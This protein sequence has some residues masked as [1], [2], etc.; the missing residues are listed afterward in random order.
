MTTREQWLDAAL[1]LHRLVYQ[2]EG[3]QVTVG[4]RDIDV[5]IV[6]PPDGAEVIRRLEEGRTPRETADWYF[7]EYGETLDIH[8]LVE[9]LEECQFLRPPDAGERPP[10]EAVRWRRLGRVLFSLP[11]L[12]S[13]GLAI[14]AAAVAAAQKPDLLPRYEHMFFSSY[15]SISQLGLFLIGIPLIM[16]HEAFHALAGRR[17]GLNSRLRLDRRLYFVVLETSMDGLVTV[18]RRQRYLPI[19]AG[20]LFDVVSIASMMLIAD[21]TRTPEGSF[22]NVG[23]LCLAVALVSWLRVLWQFNFYLRTDLY[24]LFTTVLGLND[25]HGVTKQVIRNRFHRLLGHPERVVGPDGWDPADVRASRWYAWL[26]VVGYTVSLVSFAWLVLPATLHIITGVAERFAAGT[27][28][29]LP[30]LIDSAVVTAAALG[31]LAIWFALRAR[32]RRNAVG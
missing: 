24:V 11:V 20:L 32:D 10:P 3:E 6:V 31:Q 1:S 28:T 5:Y 8:D 18:P 30:E 14:V 16:V 13:F 15:Y 29:P 2:P 26:V 19:L 17:L 23:R 21:L 25:L 9:S 22:S 7:T 27:R 12:L 4:R